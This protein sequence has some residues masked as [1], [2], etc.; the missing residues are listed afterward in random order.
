MELNRPYIDEPQPLVFHIFPPSSSRCGRSTP[1]FLEG[2][3]EL[4]LPDSSGGSWLRILSSLSEEAFLA[5]C[6]CWINLSLRT[7]LLE[8]RDLLFEDILR[9]IRF[10]FRGAGCAP[11]EAY[12]CEALLPTCLCLDTGL[13]RC[14]PEGGC[15]TLAHSTRSTRW[16]GLLLRG[17]NTSKHSKTIQSSATAYQRSCS[18]GVLRAHRQPTAV[19]SRQH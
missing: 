10:G 2:V 17:S 4:L 13:R 5:A 6:S 16:K 11:A 12:S 19:T 1:G 15:E 3:P 9:L 14:G 7:L 18:T 8:L